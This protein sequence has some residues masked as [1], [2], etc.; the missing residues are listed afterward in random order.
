[1]SNTRHLLEDTPVR[2]SV[3]FP[4][5]IGIEVQ[6]AERSYQAVTE[7]ISANGVLFSADEIP[8]VGARVTFR[9]TMPAALMGG[10]EDVLLDCIGR[11]VRHARPGKKLRAAAVIDEY[12]LRA[13]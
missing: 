11:I 6:T 2:T 13:D 1:L 12:L 7:D 5:H 9:L 3:R 8:P 4:L 10:T